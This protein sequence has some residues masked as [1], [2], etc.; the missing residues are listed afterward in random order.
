MPER[1]AWID[2]IEPPQAT[3]RLKELYDVVKTPHGTV[4]NVM[5]VHSLRPETMHGHVVLYRSILHHPDITLP[6][7][8]L[9]CVAAY[10]SLINNC[11]YSL[12]HH[13][14]NARRLLGDETRADAIHA[15]L[16]ARAPERAF[17]GKELGLMRYAAKLTA[18]PGEMVEDDLAEARA[19][20]A[21]DAEIL[22]VNQV[23]AYFGYSNRLLNGLGVSL[24]GDTIGYYEKG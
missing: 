22:E 5:K 12:T 2:I 6:L 23:C 20:G 15:A 16:Q 11:A 17:E 8:Y 19:G 10:V 13:F 14:A 18:A 7:W 9:E 3:G 1:N 21:T 24:A 4:D